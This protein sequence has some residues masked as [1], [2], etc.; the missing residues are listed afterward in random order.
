MPGH[1]DE[2]VGIEELLRKVDDSVAQTLEGKSLQS[3]VVE[4]NRL[5]P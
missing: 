3:L 2:E 1:A 5:A 4:Q